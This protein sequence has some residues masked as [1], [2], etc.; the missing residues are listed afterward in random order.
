MQ[1]KKRCLKKISNGNKYMVYLIFSW[2]IF[3]YLQS[4][5][6]NKGFLSAKILSIFFGRQTMISI[7]AVAG[8]SGN[9]CRT[10]RPDCSSV[11]AMTAMI[12]SL[13]PYAMYQFRFF[14]AFSAE[15]GFGCL[16]GAVKLA[17]L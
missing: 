12:V 16:I 9:G 10:D 1:S 11:A 8:H 13:N 17:C 6:G 3:W 4:K 14:L 2:G 7:M 15:S 5:L